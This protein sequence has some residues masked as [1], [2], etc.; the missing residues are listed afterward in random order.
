MNEQG[1]QCMTTGKTEQET[2]FKCSTLNVI[3]KE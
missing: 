2:Q 1:I 3:E